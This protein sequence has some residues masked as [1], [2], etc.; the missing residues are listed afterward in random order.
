[1]R[2]SLGN[3]LNI[4]SG[5]T[6]GFLVVA[7]ALP[8]SAYDFKYPVHNGGYLFDRP[9]E[10]ACER[11]D[12][13]CV[14]RMNRTRHPQYRASGSYISAATMALGIRGMCVE[15]DSEW[16]FHSSTKLSGRKSASGNI[17]FRRFY[18]AAVSAYLDQ[19]EALSS[20]ELTRLTGSDLERLGVSQCR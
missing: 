19:A 13:T 3:L 9:G 15:P 6:A 16:Y 17:T 7:T 4:L 8:A 18:P 20:T 12:A 2:I 11:M 5:L 14:I 10:I 1:M